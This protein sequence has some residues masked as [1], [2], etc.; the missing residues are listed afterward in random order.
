MAVLENDQGVFA[1]GKNQFGQLGL[2]KKTN[3]VFNPTRV[4]AFGGDSQCRQAALGE[5]HSVFLM[6]NNIV[7]TCGSNE[8]GQ[9]GIAV[10]SDGDGMFT[11]RGNEIE[12]SP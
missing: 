7:Y 10:D 12:Q 5:N 6:S 9:L 8:F 4:N 11:S 1:W 2:G 3:Q